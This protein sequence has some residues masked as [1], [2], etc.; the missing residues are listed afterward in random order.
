MFAASSTDVH[1]ILVHVANELE[2]QLV[3]KPY[4]WDQARLRVTLGI[5]NQA[6]AA[7]HTEVD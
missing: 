2:C 1:A 5:V 6:I 3:E 7:Y 4:E